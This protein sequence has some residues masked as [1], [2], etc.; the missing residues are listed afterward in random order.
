MKQRLEAELAAIPDA[1]VAQLRGKAEAFARELTEMCAGPS[2]CFVFCW[3][4]VVF[5]FLIERMVETQYVLR[6]M[7]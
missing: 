4:F 7:I 6:A 2:R 1:Q 3:F 5:L